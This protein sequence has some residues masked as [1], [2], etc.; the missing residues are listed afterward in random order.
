MF[1]PAAGNKGGS[2]MSD[3]ADQF[4]RLL[5]EHISAIVAAGGAVGGGA[6]GYVSGRRRANAEAFKIEAEAQQIEAETIVAPFRALLAG[7]EA[8]ARSDSL[9]IADLTREVQELRLEVRELRKAL[10]MR[11]HALIESG[12]KKNA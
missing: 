5:S 8:Q 1:P 3:A 7:Y 10:D 4:I 6:I 2:S 11:V 9:R 12:A